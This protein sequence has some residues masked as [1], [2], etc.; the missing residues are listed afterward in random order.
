MTDEDIFYSG[1]FTHRELIHEGVL[2]GLC[3]LMYQVQGH[4]CSC[5]IQWESQ[6]LSSEPF[7][8]ASRCNQKA[9]DMVFFFPTYPLLTPQRSLCSA[10]TQ[11]SSTRLMSSFSL[12]CSQLPMLAAN[13][14]PIVWLHHVIQQYTFQ[15]ASLPPHF[16]HTPPHI[17]SH[18]LLQSSTTFCP[19][20]APRP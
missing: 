12:P 19:G 10:P 16:H 4:G 9:S 5:L 3:D 1:S 14:V 11:F 13:E 15:V 6:G 8:R 20:I 7:F 18:H 17:L 2:L